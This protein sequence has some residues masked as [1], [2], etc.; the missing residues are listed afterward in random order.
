M[1]EVDM[2][3][4]RNQPDSAIFVQLFYAIENSFYCASAKSKPKEQ[5]KWRKDVKKV[6]YIKKALKATTR[7]NHRKNQ[8]EA[9]R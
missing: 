2:S 9:T 5:A 7:P 1:A 8:L 3:F 4:L 6:C